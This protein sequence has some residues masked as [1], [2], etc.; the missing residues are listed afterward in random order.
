[1]TPQ[2]IDY[3]SLA[4]DYARHR[5]VHPGVLQQLL[6]VIEQQQAHDLLEV[7]CGT[8]NYL[9]AISRVSGTRVV[10]ID[11]SPA[12]LEQLRARLPGAEVTVAEA[13]SLPFADRSLDLIFSVDVIHHVRDRDAYFAEAVRILRPGGWICTVTDS[14]E[15][16]AARV[17][18]SS[19]FPE[20]VPHELRRYPSIP[21]LRSEM[22][23]AGFLA[24]RED[25]ADLHYSLTDSTAY[26]DRAYS[27]L[28]LISDEEHARG[29]E[30]MER[31]LATG[32]IGARSLYTLLW[33]RTR[34]S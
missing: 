13:E 9:E 29:V 22:E 33:G 2:G 25:H 4:D 1:M 34:S 28:H 21:R 17:P 19:H 8:G 6:A 20:T 14:A 26:R 31:E 24:L 10:G 18:L 16:I 27:S 30:R 7:G 3:Q 12:M 23:R 11:P 32:P 5:R 15:D